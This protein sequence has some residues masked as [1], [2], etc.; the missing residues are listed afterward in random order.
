MK[1]MR[2]HSALA[3]LATLLVLG[4]GAKA[5][6]ARRR[7]NTG[8]ESAAT[9]RAKV[10]DR[11][12]MHAVGLCAD[13]VATGCLNVSQFDCRQLL[14]HEFSSCAALALSEIRGVV[15]AR[16][17]SQWTTYFDDCAFEAVRSLIDMDREECRNA[18]R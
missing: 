4:C 9:F 5:E 7:E 15:D 13:L 14:M 1:T 18:L 16:Q 3:L 6:E 8:A 12:T 17:R 2:R 10:E 11:A